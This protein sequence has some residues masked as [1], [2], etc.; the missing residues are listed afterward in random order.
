MWACMTQYVRDQTIQHPA[1]PQRPA[2]R[3]VAAEVVPVQQQAGGGMVA[4]N[5]GGEDDEDKGNTVVEGLQYQDLSED[6]QRREVGQR[7]WARGP[8]TARHSGTEGTR[9][10]KATAVMEC[11]TWM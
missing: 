10:R 9:G 11:Q 2:R 6:A 5:D 4:G 8:A 7:S 3:H 1:Q